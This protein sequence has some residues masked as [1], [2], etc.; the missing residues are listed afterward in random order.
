MQVYSFVN[1]AAEDT[2]GQRGRVQRCDQLASRQY[3][4]R[5]AS[6]AEYFRYVLCML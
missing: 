5:Q 2:F 6:D 1:E 4:V 3:C